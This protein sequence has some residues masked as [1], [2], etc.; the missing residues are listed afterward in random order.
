MLRNLNPMLYLILMLLCII[1]LESLGSTNVPGGFVSGTWNS[2]GSPYL[3]QGDITVNNGQTLTI[4]PGVEVVFQ[5]FYK[6]NVYGNI[7]CTGSTMQPITFRIQDTT[8]W[9]ND[10]ISNG[11]WKGIILIDP[12][13]QSFNDTLRFEHCIFK[14]TKYG[15]STNTYDGLTLRS[16]RRTVL[17]SCEFYHNQQMASNATGRLLDIQVDS[18]SYFLMEDCSFHDNY[19]RLM[20]VSVIGFSSTHVKNQGKILRCTFDNNHC[21][22]ALFTQSC[23][24]TISFNEF[25]HNQHVGVWD[26][27]LS[28]Q[29]D[30]S[31]VYHNSFHHNINDKTGAIFSGLS[32]TTIDGNLICN[33]QLVA[34][35][36]GI[37]DGGAGISVYG[38]FMQAD[39]VNF[40]NIK[41]NIIANNYS[42][43]EC[44]G[45]KIYHCNARIANNTIIN[46]SSV[47]FGC[48][49]T[50][51]CPYTSV[52]IKNNI[53]RGNINLNQVSGS[54][55]DTHDI[56]SLSCG[57]LKVDYNNV[58]LPL[59]QFIYFG[60]GNASGDTSHNQTSLNPQLINPTPTASVTDDATI[61]NFG[62]S[63]TSLCIN[64]GDTSGT[65]M[66]VLD[67]NL[68]PRWM[69]DNIDRGAAF[70][71]LPNF[72]FV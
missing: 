64:S 46:N 68:N 58:E 23:Y 10:S 70:V 42:A 25:K 13:Y 27:T 31:L 41:N 47:G 34:G 12:L 21:G 33:N 6:L 19:F 52:L 55:F 9:H 71:F 65:M 39:T 16:N 7:Q 49:I 5:G 50:I 3:V 24:L 28:M 53:L 17:R 29:K 54:I 18:T 72:W 8:G 14:D 35:N 4:Q 57:S 11:G 15:Y 30:S 66:S 22:A 2:S 1:S 67:Y 32:T 37:T 61:R 43:Y 56:Y 69:Y 44:G 36:C 59:S 51:I 48:G 62:L 40:F 38:Q 26:A 45:M 20:M 60:S 63:S